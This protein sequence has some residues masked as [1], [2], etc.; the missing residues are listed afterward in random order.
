MSILFPIMAG[1]IGFIFGIF[2]LLQIVLC[3][4]TKLRITSHL[5]TLS[6]I[7]VPTSKAINASIFRTAI[8][9]AILFGVV[10]A[11]III[12][13]IPSCILGY[14]IGVALAILAGFRR[15]GMRVENTFDYIV[16]NA[17]FMPLE[18]RIKVASYLNNED[19]NKILGVQPAQETPVEVK[20]AQ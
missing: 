18:E 5:I 8:T 7:T 4:R 1:V 10:T 9:H 13:L 11:L 16:K 3:I 15:T 12:K 14:G 17:R 2:S 20:Q 19:V 6:L